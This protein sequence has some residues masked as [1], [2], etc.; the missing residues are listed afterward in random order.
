MNVNE[1]ICCCYSNHKSVKQNQYW[2]LDHGQCSMQ[3]H[4]IL[5]RYGYPCDRK[6]FAAEQLAQGSH[7]HLDEGSYCFNALEIT[8]IYSLRMHKRRCACVTYVK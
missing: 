4:Q 3:L 1:Y 8:I 2:S 7:G 6:T 5:V